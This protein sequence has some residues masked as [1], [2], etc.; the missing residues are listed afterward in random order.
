MRLT[1]LLALVDKHERDDLIAWLTVMPLL[2]MPDEFLH[3]RSPDPGAPWAIDDGCHRAVM[4]SLLGVESVP[5][6]VGE[7]N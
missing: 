4:L 3:S 1:S 2:V 5:A 6:L 7:L